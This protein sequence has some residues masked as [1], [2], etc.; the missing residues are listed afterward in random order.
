[1][2]IEI[3]ILFLHPSFSHIANNSDEMDDLDVT[4]LS[5]HLLPE[6]TAGV[7]TTGDM[8]LAEAAEPESNEQ[9]LISHFLAFTLLLLSSTILSP[10]ILN[11]FDLT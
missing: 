7:E 9:P 5:S 3:M 8:F 1:M 2:L 6:K 10:R 11:Y 4:Y